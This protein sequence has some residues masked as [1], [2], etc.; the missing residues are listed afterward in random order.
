MTAVAQ[1]GARA[2]S[3]VPSGFGTDIQGLRA[4]AVPYLSA[5]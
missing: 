5:G 3:G 2:S 1:R 4:V